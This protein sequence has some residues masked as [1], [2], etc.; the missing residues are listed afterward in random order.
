MDGQE[1]IK[2][3]ED[4]IE[5][6]LKDGDD[7]MDIII[8]YNSIIN[9]I[10]E[11]QEYKALKLSPKEIKAMQKELK[12]TQMEYSAKNLILSEFRKLGTLDEVKEIVEKYKME[13]DK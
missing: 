4:S 6:L 11:L 10:E 13:A 5:F 12:D 2:K 9:I 1:I 3:L 7:S 8:L